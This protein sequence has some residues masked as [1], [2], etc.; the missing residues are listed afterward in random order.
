MLK[1]L[2]KHNLSIIYLFLCVIQAA[3]IVAQTIPATPVQKNIQSPEV[4]K[5]GAV[6]FRFLAPNAKKVMLIMDDAK[7]RKMS[8]DTA[9]VWS[10]LE[11]FAPDVYR[12]SF[13][14][15]GNNMPDP[16]NPYIKPLFKRALGQSLVHVPGPST[17]S[18]E[19]NDVPHGV[20]SQHFFRSAIIGDQRD[21]R[22]Y[23]PPGY[24]PKRPE[25]YPV[26]YLFHGITD[27]TSAWVTAGRE[28]IIMDNLIAQGKAK[29]M[30]IVNT[31]GYGAPEMFD[32]G[33]GVR[34]KQSYEKNER[35][36]V[37]ATLKEVIPMVEGFYN[38]GKT[39]KYRAVAGLSMG[40]GQSLDI[41]L[42]HPDVFDYV[43]GFSPAVI[44][45]DP[46]Y[47][48]AFPKLDESINQK[49]RLIWIAIGRDD[50][51]TP[52]VRKYIEWLKTKNISFEYK[53]SDGVHS[54][55]VWRRYLSEFTPLL[56]K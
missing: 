28:N 33:S 19:V 8:I 45:L 9:G 7:P 52:S 18:W 40:G 10:Y 34:N 32:P 24:D 35:L 21:M 23:T 17:L 56:F 20:L 11:T 47:T 26:L 31:L 39:K 30:I 22:V 37:A 25:P 49:L 48:K 1:S 14:V 16:N 55:Q 5:F 12:Y 50:Y 15:D 44:L 46:D 13:V 41:G 6:T 54:Y 51:L 36:F 38:V 27:E 29:P 2:L 53:E 43:G 42:N 4:D 3:D